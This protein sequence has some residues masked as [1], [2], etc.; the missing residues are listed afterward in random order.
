MCVHPGACQCKLPYV[1]EGKSGEGLAWHPPSRQGRA[2]TDVQSQL[3]LISI[4][5]RCMCTSPETYNSVCT[6]AQLCADG[7]VCT[8]LL[9]TFDSLLFAARFIRFCSTFPAPRG[10][11]VSACK[12]VQRINWAL[13]PA[14]FLLLLIIIYCI[15]Q[16]P[17]GSQSLHPHPTSILV[18]TTLYLEVDPEKKSR[19]NRKTCTRKKR[20]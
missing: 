19:R 7:S 11:F 6:I 18:V 20:A 15:F 5:S 4:V 2:A 14:C 3:Q 8:F 10:V 17:P 9:P 16:L 13:T 12:Y 1:T